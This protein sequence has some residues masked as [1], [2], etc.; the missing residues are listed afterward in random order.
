MKWMHPIPVIFLI[1]LTSCGIFTPPTPVVLRETV[2]VIIT[3]DV[4]VTR[5]V[6]V[7]PTPEPSPTATPAP[8]LIF[9]DDFEGGIGDWDIQEYETGAINIMN[10]LLVIESNHPDWL[11]PVNHPDLE[12]LDAYTLDVDISHRSGSENSAAFISFRWWDTE[13]HCTFEVTADGWFA[14]YCVI[15]DD[16]YDTIS[17]TRSP[18]IKTGTNANHIRLVDTGQQ[19]TFNINNNFLASIP[20]TYLTLGNVRLGAGILEE[21]ETVWS[22]DNLEVREYRP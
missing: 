22:F 20:L 4:E 1:L 6:L 15:E 19:V 5:Q 2:E 3:K 13:N 16:F 7:S 10:G 17:W 14:L 9:I 21:G 11:I 18:A 12:S 8:P